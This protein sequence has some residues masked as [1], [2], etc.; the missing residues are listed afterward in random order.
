MD[1]RIP[2]RNNGI[3]G[4]MIKGFMKLKIVDL[5]VGAGGFTLDFK[6]FKAGDKALC[7]TL[8]GPMTQI[9]DYPVFFYLS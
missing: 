6:Q 4:F 9:L 3:I 8:N 1:F 5:F 7:S 2:L